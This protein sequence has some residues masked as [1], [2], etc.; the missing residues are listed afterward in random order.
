MESKKQHT[1]EKDASSDD[2]D[3]E[4]PEHL[5]FSL[6]FLSEDVKEHVV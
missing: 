4:Q 1:E 6:K 5:E 2:S 3:Y